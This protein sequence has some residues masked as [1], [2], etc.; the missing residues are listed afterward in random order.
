MDKIKVGIPRSILYYYFNDMWL[1]FFEKLGIEVV[2]SPKTNKKIIN[3]GLNYTNDEMCLA[4]K[5]Y[6]GH[7]SYLKD[8]CDYILVP[9]IEN[10]GIEN[11]TC[12][13]F[14]S[15]YDLVNNIFDVNILN[16]NIAY[17]RC[18]TE[19]KA[20]LKIGKKLGKSKVESKKAYVFAKAMSEKDKKKRIHENMQKLLSSKLKVLI[21]GHPY[22]LYDEYVGRPILKYLKKLNVEWISASEFDSK[23]TNK[24]S[25][26]LSKDIY[27][28]YSKELIGAIKLV[29]D[30]IDGV[31]FVSSFPCGPD[32]LVND[33]VIRR[34][35]IPYLNLVIDDLDSLA[36]IETRLESFVDIIEQKTAI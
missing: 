24:L 2:V 25:N 28:K 11:Q 20:F 15:L 36:G 33:L 35:D 31:I 34:I 19:K 27:W 9:R 32:S 23:K 4:L 5:V 29:E 12:T 7:V 1:Y 30:K 21:V 8:K 6:M 10:Y 22:N 14:L 16:Y 17:T 18:H 26:L 3:D 13:N